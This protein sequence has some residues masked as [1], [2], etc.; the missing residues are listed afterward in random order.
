[1][2]YREPIATFLE[3]ARSGRVC[4]G[5]H[6]SGVSPALVELYGLARVDF[7][8][9]GGEVEAMDAAQLENLLRAANASGTVPI[10]KLRRPSPEA[11]EDTMNYGAPFIMVPHVTSAPQLEQLVAASRFAPVGTRG[12][13]PVARYNAY[14]IA[15]LDE[16]RDAANAASCIIPLIEDREAMDQLDAICAVDGVEIISIGP[17]DLAQSFGLK[18]SYL[19]PTVMEAIEEIADA[20]RRHGKAVMAPMWTGPQT[21]TAAK[22][23]QWQM[24]QLIARGITLLYGIEFVLLAEYFRQLMPLRGV[25]VRS[26]EEAAEVEAAT[27]S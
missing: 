7:V 17:R 5:V 13:C 15:E 19:N 2:L 27:G 18:G 12:L 26:D 8:V 11:V 20:A 1:M 25:R 9:V 6:S 10:A 16:S 3:R 23:V 21:D 4:V 24:D 22:T 14:S